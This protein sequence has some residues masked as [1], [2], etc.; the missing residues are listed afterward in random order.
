MCTQI[1]QLHC[2]T[3]KYLIS[4]N[5]QFNEA[6]TPIDIKYSVCTRSFTFLLN[7]LHSLGYWIYDT[8][9]HHGA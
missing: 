1:Y 7:M 2:C 4:H 5:E 3:Y 6:Y 8:S 9:Q